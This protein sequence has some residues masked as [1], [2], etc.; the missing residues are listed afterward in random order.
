LN[1]KRIKPESQKDLNN[2]NKKLKNLSEQHI[3]KLPL[4]N[5]NLIEDY[6]E[7]EEEAK[8]KKNL[9]IIN[10]NIYYKISKFYLLNIVLILL[11]LKK[12]FLM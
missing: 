4:N 7:S 2:S 10:L 1:K 8:G 12:K 5:R 3:N 9:F 6:S 11:K